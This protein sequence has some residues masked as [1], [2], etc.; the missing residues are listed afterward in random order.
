MTQQDTDTGET[1][2]RGIF[3]K[4]LGSTVYFGLGDEPI[5]GTVKEVERGKPF[6]DWP[7]PGEVVTFKAAGGD[8]EKTVREV[9]PTDE[10]PIVLGH[11]GKYKRTNFV[12]YTDYETYRIVVLED[13]RELWPA[14]DDHKSGADT[15]ETS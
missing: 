15:S 5:K 4:E 2:Y 10:Y 12:E 7:E 11:G 1:E 13:G 6:D 3:A 14:T 8:V 9:N